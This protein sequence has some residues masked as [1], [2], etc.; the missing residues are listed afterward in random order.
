MRS[1]DADDP[2]MTLWKHCENP[3]I[4]LHIISNFTAQKDAF[5]MGTTMESMWHEISPWEWSLCG[6]G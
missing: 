3:T 1:D 4:I 2:R 6:V 5:V